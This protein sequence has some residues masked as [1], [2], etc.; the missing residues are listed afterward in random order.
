MAIS[1]NVHRLVESMSK[2][3]ATRYVR[4][5]RYDTFPQKRIVYSLEELLYRLFIVPLVGFL[6]APLTYGLACVRGDWRY[7]HDTLTRERIL[8]SLDGVL[9]DQLNPAERTRVVRNFFRRRSC[10]AI[11]VMCLAGRGRAL[12]RL[13]EIRGLE[14]IEA[15]LA[16][17]KG[18]I[19]CNAHFGLFSGSFSLFGACGFPVT[20]VGNWRSMYDS[21]MSPV[22]RFLWRLIQE[23]RVVRHRRRPNFE[24]QRG[25]F[26]TAFRIVEV[27]RSNEL[28]GI[29]ID[30]STPAADR[31]R[32]V[33]VDFLGRQVLLLLW[34]VTIAQLTGSP[35]L[36]LVLHRLADWRNQVLEI[37]PPVPL[38]GAA[39]TAFK[40]CLAVEAPIR[41]NPAYWDLWEYPK[42]LVD[43]GLL[44]TYG[45]H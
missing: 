21:S 14:H 4:R 40:R 25:P 34:S 24:P 5:Y 3:L 17:G 12:M 43:L 30:V 38:D 41:Q 2:A 11:D 16:A 33:P 23:K 44:S 8:C 19:L 18:V 32:A 36:V 6:P 7:R 31:A 35:V 39:V 10:E 9:G 37:S 45:Q 27:L 20:V 28:I 13:I 26:G 22:Q 15:A 42:D 29:P 1:M